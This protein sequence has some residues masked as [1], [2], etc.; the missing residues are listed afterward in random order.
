MSQANIYLQL[1]ARGNIPR[2]DGK[3]L[4]KLESDI[5]TRSCVLDS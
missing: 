5:S 1:L 2:Y 3:A 4:S